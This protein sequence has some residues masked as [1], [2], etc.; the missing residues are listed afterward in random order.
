MDIRDLILK[1][2]TKK[3][4]T[5]ASDIMKVTGFSRVY[6]NRYF[7]DLR[8]E[9]KITLIGRSNQAHYVLTE[10]RAGQ[11]AQKPARVHRMLHN[12][13][14]SEDVVLD[15]IK[16]DSMIYSG[17]PSNIERII[18]YAFTEMLNNAIEHS[19][20]EHIDVVFVRTNE[21]VWFDVSDKG[22]GIFNNI[23]QKKSLKTDLDAIQDLIK[24]KETT[25]PAFHSGEGIFF[26][27]KLAD[28]F[29]IKSSQKSV[30]FDNIIADVFVKEL[31]RPVSG[32]KVFFS[33]NLESKRSISDVFE[34]YT[35]DSLEFSKTEVKVKLFRAG[36]EYISRSQARRI[37]SGLERFRTVEL[38][39]AGIHTIGQG[40]ADEIFRVWRSQHPDTKII[41]RNMAENVKFMIKHVVPDLQLV[42]NSENKK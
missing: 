29:T 19:H 18:T 16:S 13:G 34:K 21:R 23:R 42:N 10:T 11:E 31:A 27:S 35:G 14:L 25:A 26:T 9:G 24:G 41:P 28:R 36:V 38:D 7:R 39:F 6:I 20:S 5:K 1:T 30:I 33:I 8:N 3:G 40:F 37:V 15:K 2:L 32:T 22:I 12:K 17:L 4:K